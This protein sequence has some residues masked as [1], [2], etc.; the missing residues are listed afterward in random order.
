MTEELKVAACYV[1]MWL[2]VT[3][4]MMVLGGLALFALVA[5]ADALLSMPAARYY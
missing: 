3:P 1:L 4:V 5:V 2:V